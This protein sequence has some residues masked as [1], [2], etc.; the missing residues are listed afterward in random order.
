MLNTQPMVLSFQSPGAAPE[1]PSACHS[2]LLK[3][4][5]ASAWPR[6]R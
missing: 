3:T 4:R 6:E 5:N 1:I 2:G